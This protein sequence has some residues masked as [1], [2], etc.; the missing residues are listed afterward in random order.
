MGQELLE[1]NYEEL[2]TKASGCQEELDGNNEIKNR[3]A[4]L[5]LDQLAVGLISYQSFSEENKE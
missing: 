2:F 4:Q 3:L 1:F 5:G